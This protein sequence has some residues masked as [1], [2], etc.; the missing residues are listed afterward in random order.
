MVATHERPDPTRY[1]IPVPSLIDAAEEYGL[2]C[3]TGGPKTK[4]FPAAQEFKPDAI[5]SVL[6]RRI[7]PPCILDLVAEDCRFNVHPGVLPD[8]KGFSANVHAILDG[9]T[10]SG[11]TVHTMIEQVDQGFAF[12]IGKFPL[13]PDATA[14]SAWV[15]SQKLVG[16]CFREVWVEFEAAWEA[17]G[18]EA[19]GSDPTNWLIPSFLLPLDAGAYH[20]KGMPN[21][22]VI[23]VRWAPEFIDRFIRA[24][25]CPPWDP[26]C[27]LIRSAKDPDAEPARYFVNNM[28]EFTELMADEG[29][30]ALIVISDQPIDKQ[31]WYYT[32]K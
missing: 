16:E 31:L 20:G 4:V 6:Y 23:D 3:V 28:N 5:V 14:L 7:L 24:L 29:K 13:G 32:G 26:A 1:K 9:D 19:R 21:D 30:K 17:R 27:V 8:H 22:G 15:D 11:V 2:Q 10:H 18:S 25:Y 12:K